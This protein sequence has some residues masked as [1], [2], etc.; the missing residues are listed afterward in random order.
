[1]TRAVHYC[2]TVPASGM[3][4]P[5]YLNIQNPDCRL[6]LCIVL[7]DKTNTVTQLTLN[8]DQ[9]SRP[10]SGLYLAFLR[11]LLYFHVLNIWKA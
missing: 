8:V 5:M 9:S 11:W 4:S 3:D 7:G 6:Q 1:M 10:Y 2:M